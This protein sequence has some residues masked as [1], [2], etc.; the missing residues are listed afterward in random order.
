MN[1]N[2][3]DDLLLSDLVPGLAPPRAPDTSRYEREVAEY[4]AA[5]DA[6]LH[7]KVVSDSEQSL[8]ISSA[9]GVAV[10]DK[11]GLSRTRERLSRFFAAQP[12][13]KVSTF[14]RA[15]PNDKGSK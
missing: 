3:S 1:P 7:G 10:M 5:Q 15:A 14:S 9:I 13:A 6:K 12:S 11:R 4:N 2:S 8:I